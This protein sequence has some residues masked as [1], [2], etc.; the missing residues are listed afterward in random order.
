MRPSSHTL[1]P[2][3][4]RTLPPITHSPHRRCWCLWEILQTVISDATLTVLLPPSETESFEE[5][6]VEEFDSITTSLS[7]V[8]VRR[9]EAFKMEDQQMILGAVEQGVGFTELNKLVSGQLREWLATQAQAA[10]ARL[11][12]AER[13]G[14]SSRPGENIAPPLTS[15][16]GTR[17]QARARTKQ[18]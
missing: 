5:A 14:T 8:D 2:P 4:Q 6:L 7:K 12:E 3:S 15:K 1:C 18:N 11:P 10:L 9:A 13:A 16:A 17:Q